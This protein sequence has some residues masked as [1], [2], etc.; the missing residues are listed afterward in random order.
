MRKAI[1]LAG[2][3]LA[4]LAAL[5]LWTW[6]QLN[7]E[8]EETRTLREQLARAGSAPLVR[9]EPKALE[10]EGPAS[11]ADAAV[12]PELPGLGMTF[13]TNMEELFRDPE[14]LRAW[15]MQVRATTEAIYP[16]VQR[17]LKLSPDMSNRLYDLLVDHFYSMNESMARA[18]DGE[19][20]DAADEARV[21]KEQEEI[22]ALLGPVRA[23]AWVAYKDN[24]EF[25]A[26]VN[27]LREEMGGGPD[28]LRDEQVEALIPIYR[29]A[30]ELTPDSRFP[31]DFIP[32]MEAI[33]PAQWGTNDARSRDRQKAINAHVLEGARSI[34]DPK[35]M[36]ELER[37]TRRRE[38]LEEASAVLEQRP[39][40]L[41]ERTRASGAPA[42][43]R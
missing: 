28:G 13:S 23:K 39:V 20:N 24:L 41:H 17:A 9:A 4:A 15:R 1:F 38:E 30:A 33:D 25:R 36:T 26:E 29:A 37:M 21:Q 40:Q 12:A 6:R 35:Q 22:A 18:V 2:V 42:S 16:D 11:P 27:R 19:R 7:T 34:L 10:I 32:S 3:A 8:R 5:N 43:A 14:Y 31:Q